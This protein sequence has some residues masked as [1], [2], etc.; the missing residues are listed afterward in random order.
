MCSGISIVWSA[1]DASALYLA[2]YFIQ[3]GYYDRFHQ[4]IVV[5]LLGVSWLYS[6]ALW[7][8]YVFTA[9]IITS[10]AHALAVLL[11]LVLAVVLRYLDTFELTSE[12]GERRPLITR[13]SHNSPL[14]YL[15]AEDKGGVKSK[16][17]GGVGIL[18]S[19]SK[20]ATNAIATSATTSTLRPQTSPKIVYRDNVYAGE[21]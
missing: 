10:I 7:I 3:R 19:P 9:D 12:K 18:Q 11:G 2:Y 17:G 1:L 16:G 4:R 6:I 20:G 5:L 13:H 14:L 15:P 21:Q 8:Y